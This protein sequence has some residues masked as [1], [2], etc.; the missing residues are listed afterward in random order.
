MQQQMTHVPASIICKNVL[1][2]SHIANRKKISRNAQQCGI[3]EKWPQTTCR[4][5]VHRRT[6]ATKYLGLR[7]SSIAVPKI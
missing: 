6:M 2:V 7:M 1:K 4:G 3:A 5:T